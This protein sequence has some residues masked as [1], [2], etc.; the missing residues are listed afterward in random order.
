MPPP[1]ADGRSVYGESEMVSR[2]TAIGNGFPVDVN[3][4]LQERLSTEN[5]EN[6]ENAQRIPK[7]GLRRKAK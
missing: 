4:E 7:L 2:R 6:T 1:V 5:T 3:N